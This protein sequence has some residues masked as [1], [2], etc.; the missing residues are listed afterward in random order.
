LPTVVVKAAT[1]AATIT[2]AKRKRAKMA[3]AKQ[4]VFFRRANLSWY[5]VG[6]AA[7]ASILPIYWVS[8]SLLHDQSSSLS[9][10]EIILYQ[11]RHP[12]EQVVASSSS[13]GG[14]RFITARKRKNRVVFFDGGSI[15]R[16][17]GD[18]EHNRKPMQLP[19]IATMIDNNRK[20]RSSTP[21]RGRRQAGQPK[22]QPS[23]LSLLSSH[24][25]SSRTE[26]QYLDPRLG[27][28]GGEEETQ[29]Q[30][31]R[32][33][34]PRQKQ[35]NEN[36]D[37]DDE[38]E[39]ED[40]DEN[41]ED[42]EDDDDAGDQ[43]PS[44]EPDYGSI[45][46]H[47]AGEKKR[48][49][50]SSSSSWTTKIRRVISRYDA[51]IAQHQRE[52]LLLQIEKRDNDH[53]NEYYYHDEELAEFDGSVEDN[54][55]YRPNWKS[56]FYPV[57]NAFHE[58]SLS[59]HLV[60]D[61]SDN[62]L[63]SSSS[64]SSSTMTY[65]GSGSWR[66]AWKL[67]EN[68]SK[69]KNDVVMKIGRMKRSIDEKLLSTTAKEAIILE[70]LSASPRI[71]DIWGYCGISSY[72]ESMSIEVE[73]EIMVSS[74]WGHPD[75]VHKLLAK[76]MKMI[77]EQR[78]EQPKLKP[79]SIKPQ[80]ISFNNLTSVQRV[81]VA[82][83]MAETVAAIH[84]FD[85]GVIVNGDLHTEQF[86]RNNNGQLKLN[87]FNNAILLDWSYDNQQ[88]CQVVHDYEGTFHALEEHEGYDTVDERIDI[89]SF[90]SSLF[91]LLAGLWPH[92]EYD[93]NHDVKM[94]R[95]QDGKIPSLEFCWSISTKEDHPIEMRLIQIMEPCL[96]GNQKD[97]PSIFQ[98]LKWLN[99]LKEEIST[100]KVKQTLHTLDI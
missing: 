50:S 57:C 3:V 61:G 67:V 26:L 56:K 82:I 77:K 4:N 28:I 94:K 62:A 5:L 83:E 95:I 100:G 13:N 73:D 75:K 53:D 24:A 71:V 36:E 87:D 90:G 45:K 17:S 27:R 54:G 51:Q 21:L 47:P 37:V 2:N 80:W 93:A 1:A 38:D 23:S 20:S 42:D 48:A 11:F 63:T 52:L 43:T 89:F 33:R 60:G 55:C 58:Q 18:D 46:Y 72:V 86:L 44:W 92:W 16:G 14:G 19:T 7:I 41:V 96:A 85:G 99:K 79:S 35:E 10:F 8:M 22:R 59:S 74:L 68:D 25:S 70:R 65:L 66:D 91:T 78:Q 88:Y 15:G 29:R 9:P 6:G 32:Q 69:N 76:K 97:R 98:V 84:G 40:D 34:L 39:D 31:Q 64:S 12:T 30:R 81:D 49:S